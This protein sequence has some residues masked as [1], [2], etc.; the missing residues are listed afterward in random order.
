MRSDFCGRSVQHQLDRLRIRIERHRYCKRALSSRGKFPLAH[1]FLG[2]I[3]Q[4]RISAEHLNV[5]HSPI[6]VNNNFQSH[7][8]A[9]APSLQDRRVL[10]FHL[11]NDLAVAVLSVARGQAEHRQNQAT[12]CSGVSRLAF[13]SCHCAALRRTVRESALDHPHH[14]H[15]RL[16]T[17][18]AVF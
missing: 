12:E 18:L 17:N 15:S 5:L 2:R 10:R 14:C 7:C 9:N 6:R 8:P 11:L 3:R 16:P 1:R 13:T 4:S